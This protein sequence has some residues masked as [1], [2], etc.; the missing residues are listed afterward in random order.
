MNNDYIYKSDIDSIDSCIK[1][2]REELEK[3]QT[4]KK[5]ILKT[6]LLCE[7]SIIKLTNYVAR[8]ENI[9]IHIS[10]QL[11]GI[12]IEIK[13][14]GDE[15]PELSESG[16]IAYATHALNEGD[17]DIDS[18]VLILKANGDVV[19]YSYINGTN[20]IR[21]KTRKK[22]QNTM[23]LTLFSM[24]AAI[25]LGSIFKLFIPENINNALCDMLFTPIKTMF[26]NA[27]KIVVGP[28]IF[29]SIVTCISDFTNLS[30]LGKIGAKVISMYL[31][32]TVI[33]VVM[34]FS[35]FYLIS[36]GEF[37]MALNDGIVIEE[38]VSQSQ[39]NFSI[40]DTIVNVVPSNLLKPFV[41]SNTLQ[42]IFLAILLG[43]AVGMISN[44][45]KVIQELFSAFN[46]LFITV[47]TLIARFIPLAVFCSLFTMVCRTGSSSLIAMFSMAGTVILAL[48]AMMVVYGLLILIV[49]RINPLKF[50]QKDLS[51]MLTSFSLSSSNAAMPTNMQICTEK[52]GISPK[53]CNFSIPLGATINMDGVSIHLAIVSMFLAKVYGVE[54]AAAS[55]FSICI[56]IVILSLGT[57]GIPGASLVC[58]GILLQQIGVPLE[59]IGLIIGVDA[60][61][62][63]F[64]TLSNTTG[65]MAV[66]LIVARL[67]KLLDINKYL[68]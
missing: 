18:G 10:H 31:L 5:E 4:S 68:S 25:I 23:Y 13:S 17:E 14:K 26:I 60:L 40:I 28:V 58:T 3:H 49:G 44:Y 35:F 45:S 38:V 67:E 63:M 52:L 6:E 66:T 7:E 36:P 55:L 8:E 32:T 24:V 33:A 22:E 46:E 37:G 34:G 21:I 16:N 64:R 2:I 27:L 61:L 47:T 51:G 19:K 42:I 15:I 54:V 29:F 1:Y 11:G 43:S 41:E 20:F 56:T 62:D 53:V 9:N 57:P 48:A 12:I 59:A 50:F 39:T 30:E 65:D